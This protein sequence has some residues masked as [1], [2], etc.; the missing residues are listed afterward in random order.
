M[1]HTELSPRLRALLPAAPSGLVCPAKTADRTVVD[2]ATIFPGQRIVDGDAALACVAGIL[3]ARDRFHDS[4][5]VSQDLSTTEGSYWHGILH[6]R[7]PDAG[8]ATYWMRQ[9]GSHPVHGKLAAAS[10]QLG[11]EWLLDRGAWNAARFIDAC[12]GSDEGDA[13]AEI[14]VAIQAKEIELLLAWCAA[15]AVGAG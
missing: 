3:L 13:V 7:E 9:V 14:L 10:R 2:V 15:K 8:N 12:T 1:S 11:A 5:A 6:R 4:H